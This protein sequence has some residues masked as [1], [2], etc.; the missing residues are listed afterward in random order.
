MFSMVCAKG[1][2]FALKIREIIHTL[3]HL[4]FAPKLNA[5]H[6]RHDKGGVSPHDIPI[7]ALS[8]LQL[9]LTIT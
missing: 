7:Q 4:V 9:S 6:H 2:P 8:K 1:L 5:C 3:F